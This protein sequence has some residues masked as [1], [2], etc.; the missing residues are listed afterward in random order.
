MPNEKVQLKKGLSTNLPST[1]TPGNILFETDTGNMY[2]DVTSAENSSQRVQVKDDTKLPLA[3]G[4]LSGHLILSN[5]SMQL[6]GSG[7]NLVLTNTNSS[8]GLYLRGATVTILSSDSSNVLQLSKSG[9]NVFNRK[10]LKVATPTNDTD[11]VNKSYVD[12]AFQTLE[13]EIVNTADDYLPLKGGTMT[14]SI[15]MGNSL[16]TSLG[17]PQSDTDAT[18]K[19]YVDTKMD[20]WGDIQDLGSGAPLI[21]KPQD[22]S[23]LGTPTTMFGIS[24]TGYP[25]DGLY[26]TST[27]HFIYFESY[28]LS[29]S[30]SGVS[31]VANEGG[32]IY[33]TLSNSGT[34]LNSM[35]SIDGNLHCKGDIYLKE[36]DTDTES[37]IRFTHV[38]SGVLEIS[39]YSVGGGPVVIRGVST[40]VDS[41]DAANKSYVDAAISNVDVEWSNVSSKPFTSIG[42]GLQVSGN[43]LSVN[44]SDLVIDDGSLS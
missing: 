12:I 24:L 19:K 23:S 9:V 29:V 44:T 33:L 13:Q 14:G 10:L 26:L 36:S 27:G 20:K 30:N 21:I 31:F 42:T 6:Y 2:V 7:T 39:S 18:N 1:Y 34:S 37:S 41:T 15:D 22:Q 43:V 8:G 5:N 28:E 32:R 16:I 3:G 40:P 17:T 38:S 4:T 25:N 35:L 11:G